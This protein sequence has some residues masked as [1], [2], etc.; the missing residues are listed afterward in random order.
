MLRRACCIIFFKEGA[1]DVASK[2]GDPL[3]ARLAPEC[4]RLRLSVRDFLLVVRQSGAF[5][6][7]LGSLSQLSSGTFDFFLSQ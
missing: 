1:K 6:I 4:I 5:I 7:A 3:F 2:V